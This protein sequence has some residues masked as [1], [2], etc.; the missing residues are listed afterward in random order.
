MALAFK[1]RPLT[2]DEQKDFIGHEIAAMSEA[3]TCQMLQNF[4][5]RFQECIARE[6]KHLDK[7]YVRS[8]LERLFCRFQCK[9]VSCVNITSILKYIYTYRFRIILMILAQSAGAVEYTDCFSAEGYDPPHTH[10]HNECPRY[11]TK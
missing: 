4:K 3:M 2:T 7:F 11:D 6:V 10:T 9:L 5:V 1:R 8:K